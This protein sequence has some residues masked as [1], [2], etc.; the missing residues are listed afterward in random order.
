MDGSNFYTITII[1]NIGVP[2]SFTIKKW[3]LI[4]FMLLMLVIVGF[5]IF[6]AFNYLQLREESSILKVKLEDSDKKVTLL[7]SQIAH[8]DNEQFSKQSE[9]KQPALSGEQSLIAETVLTQP[10]VASEAFWVSDQDQSSSK[11]LKENSSV[12]VTKLDT[13]L[14]RDDLF[15]TV[16]LTNTSVEP[17]ALGG[18]FC[19]TLI[20]N[21]S[22]PPQYTLVTGGTLGENGFPSTYKS[23]RQYLLKNN[24]RTRSYR[25]KYELSQPNEYYTDAI[26]LTYSY[27]GRLLNKQVIPIDRDIFLEQ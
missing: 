22:S 17:K 2:I 15:L 4:F 16:E 5:L 10:Q 20:N 25:V 14:N 1:R 24:R 13:K 23:G 19:V 6:E 26:L 9:F 21:D 8:F 7:T 11:D 18:Y 27:K 12:E 3:K